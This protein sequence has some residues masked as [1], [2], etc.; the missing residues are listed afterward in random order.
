[1]KGDATELLELLFCLFDADQ[2]DL[3][4]L[5]DL[6]H[7]IDFRTLDARKRNGEVTLM[8]KKALQD[9]ALDESDPEPEEDLAEDRGS[10]Q[11]CVIR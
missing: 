9:F 6:E 1:M 3:V 10:D 11:K 7:T 4:G 8:A 2:D 5:T